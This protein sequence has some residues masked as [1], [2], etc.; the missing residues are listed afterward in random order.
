MDYQKAKDELLE[1]LSIL[2]RLNSAG[3][4]GVVDH[5]S[6]DCIF[7]NADV[8]VDLTRARINN[9]FGCSS[10]T[11]QRYYMSYCGSCLVTFYSNG[12]VSSHY[13]S[14]NAGELLQKV[15]GGKCKVVEIVKPAETKKEVVCDLEEV[16]A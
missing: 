3:L 4:M 10:D 2:E 1:E 12:M 5:I 7:L 11:L 8:D 14:S 13:R 6:E 15:S 16:E 9:A